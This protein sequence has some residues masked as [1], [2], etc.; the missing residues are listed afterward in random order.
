M[1][2]DKIIERIA[3]LLELADENRG[4]TPAERELATQRAHEM[5]LKY[6]VEQSELTGKSA[7]GDVSE[8]GYVVEGSM[9]EGKAMLPILIGQ[10]CFV[11]GYYEQQARFRWRV[12][13]VGRPENIAFVTTLCKALIPWL[14]TEAL[15]AFNLASSDPSQ[16]AKPRSFR[17]AFYHAATIVIRQR[18]ELQRQEVQGTGMEL[19]RNE[20]AAN[21]K[22]VEDSGVDPTPQSIR[23]Y[24]SMVGHALGERSGLRAYISGGKNLQ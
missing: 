16:E 7:K 23:G 17:R 3:K 15:A 12:V 11:Y 1:A 14:E 21:Q 4:G 20:D 9:S 24:S 10:V 6:N 19:V 2:E 13:L 22:Y 5:M 18:L 8:D